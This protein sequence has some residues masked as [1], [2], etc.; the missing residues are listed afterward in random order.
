MSAKNR[1]P[2]DVGTAAKDRCD[3]ISDAESTADLR[4]Y[5]SGAKVYRG[6]GLGQAIPVDPSTAKPLLTGVIGSDAPRT[7]DAPREHEKSW[8]KKHSDAAL[9]LHLQEGVIALD[10]DDAAALQANLQAATLTLPATAYSTARGSTSPRRHLFYRVDQTAWRSNGLLPAGGEIVDAD[11]RFA[12][13]SPSV[14]R[15]TGEPYRWFFP[16]TEDAFGPGRELDSPPLADE[17]AELPAEVAAHLTAAAVTRGDAAGICDASALEEW[18]D[19]ER[20]PEPSKRVRAAVEAVPRSDVGNPD[21][22]RLTLPWVR[23]AHETRSGRR[24]AVEQAVENYSSGY[25]RGAEK[26]AR[27]AV[28]RALAIVL[29]DSAGV[30]TLPLDEPAVKVGKKKRKLRPTDGARVLDDVRSHLERFIAYPNG[31]AASAHALWI[32]H[33][34]SVESFEN[35]P[36]I[37][38]LSPEP[39]SGKSRAMEL[40]EALVPNPLLSVNA[41]VSAIFRSIS[42]EN[43]P[44]LLLDEVDAIFVGKTES[45]E[46]LRGL[47]NSGYR[48]GAVALRSAV[49][50]K[51]V[52]VEDWPTFC[53]TALAGLNRLPDTL[54]TR[55]VV[56]RMKRRR[57]DQVVEPYRR[58]VNGSEGAELK[59]DLAS[60]I[61]GAASELRDVWP[62][63]P[64]GVADRDADVWEPL[65]AIADVAGGH[66]PATARE[67][68]VQAVTEAKSRPLSLGVQLLVDIRTVFRDRDRLATA[69]LLGELHAMETGPWA[70]IKGE[71]IDSQFLARLLSDYE[72]APRAMRIDGL[73]T[74]GYARGDFLDAWD[75]YAPPAPLPLPADIALLPEKAS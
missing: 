19:A 9:G 31:W 64:V 23:A 24:W 66:W 65:L 39:G 32:A 40:T 28:R 49:R 69:Q 26:A 27:R 11:H 51:E 10:V 50:G 46:E 74:R 41:S 22:L 43:L 30:V 48:R 20:E 60:F 56:I 34:H 5:A 53:A 21:L 42:D 13:V 2:G 14:H 72:I 3:A 54:M 73:K 55:A 68:C 8:R 63:L 44:T 47:L 58:R 29:S 61:D 52:V 15:K 4:P 67:A 57:R 18:M 16:A 75:R 17:L 62:E 25:G 7:G 59:G 1:R 38:F 12:L 35:T 37:A 71:A 45:S 33:A 36:R 6:R 70:S